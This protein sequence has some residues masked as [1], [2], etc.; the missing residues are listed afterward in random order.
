[1]CLSRLSAVKKFG[2]HEVFQVLMV[3][4]HFNRVL[5]ALQFRTPFL[6]ASDYRHQFLIVDLVVAFGRRVFFREESD[7][8]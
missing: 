7:R 3:G 6:E 8:V 5:D 4:E 2:A 1:M